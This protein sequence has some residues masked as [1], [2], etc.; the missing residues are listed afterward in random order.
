[1]HGR[2]INS[3]STVNQRTVAIDRNW[4]KFPGF[5]GTVFFIHN[6]CFQTLLTTSA[7][8]FLNIKSET[9]KFWKNT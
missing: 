6:L 4:L 9:G 8:T 5:F 1:M 7:N 2:A 3:Q